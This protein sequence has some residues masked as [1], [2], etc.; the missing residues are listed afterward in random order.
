MSHHIGAQLIVHDGLRFD[1]NTVP[2]APHHAVHDRGRP[3]E[4]FGL[5]LPLEPYLA[6]AMNTPSSP[7]HDHTHSEHDSPLGAKP[8]TVLIKQDW[9]QGKQKREEA[10]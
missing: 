8:L 2:W 3:N 4:I 1:S 10:E 7:L 9:G 5:K 6:M